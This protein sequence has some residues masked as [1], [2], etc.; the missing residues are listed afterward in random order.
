MD[1]FVDIH[2]HM[3]PGIDDG[4]RDMAEAGQMLRMARADGT[5]AMI[6]TPHCFGRFPGNSPAAIRAAFEALLPIAAAECPELRLYLGSE[7]RYE[8]SVPEQLAAGGVQTLN[9]SRYVLLEFDVHCLRSQLV[10]GVSNVI[11]SG[12][13]PIIAHAERYD[14][15]RRDDGLIDEVLDQG[16]LVQVNA[17]S[18]LGTCGLRT[19]WFCHRL[20]RRE[21]VHFV[22]SDGHRTDRRRPELGRCWKLVSKKYG[23]I[24]AKR[25]FRDN[26]LAVIADEVL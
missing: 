18:I 11:Y 8:S 3:I 26:A 12:F 17:E 2:T 7:V 25:L 9:G 10:Q 16:A 14:A 22:A 5:S 1:G 4:A 19:K 21:Q 24:Y 20:L 6:L 15:F 13:T 23:I